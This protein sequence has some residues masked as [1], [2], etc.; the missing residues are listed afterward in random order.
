MNWQGKTRSKGARP[1]AGSGSLSENWALA[2]NYWNFFAKELFMG[3][4]LSGLFGGGQSAPSIEVSD[5]ITPPT[6]AVAADP[7]SAAVRQVEQRRLKARRA[8]AGT[9]LTGKSSEKTDSLL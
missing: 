9:L 4:V 2:A 3:S 8:M 1:R 5:P 6:S 7:I